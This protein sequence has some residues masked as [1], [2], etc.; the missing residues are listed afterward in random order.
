M[1]PRRVQK[2]SQRLD[3]DVNNRLNEDEGHSKSLQRKGTFPRTRRPLASF[4]RLR[5]SHSVAVSP[6][7]LLSPFINNA[8]IACNS[9][10]RSPRVLKFHSI[11]GAT[12]LRVI[13]RQK[14]DSRG[15][16][17][18]ADATEEERERSCSENESTASSAFPQ[19]TRMTARTA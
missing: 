2:Q 10:S 17:R 15:A 8:E 18:N 4:S 1:R 14:R 12:L 13:V 19:T 9:N 5:C 6:V 3:L 7:R 11:R 16:E